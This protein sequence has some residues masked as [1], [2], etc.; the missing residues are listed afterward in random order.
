MRN[1][2][3]E[4]AG[5]S[6]LSSRCAVPRRIRGR[7]FSASDSDRCASGR[8]LHGRGAADPGGSGR[9][10]RRAPPEIIHPRSARDHGR[11]GHGHAVQRLDLQRQIA[12]AGPGGLRRGPRQDHHGEPR[13]H[14]AWAG[15]TCVPNQHD[16]LRSGRAGRIHGPGQDDGYPRR[17]HVP[18]RLGPRHRPA[19]QER[20]VWSDGGLSA[21]PEASCGAGACGGGERHLRRPRPIRADPRHLTGNGRNETIRPS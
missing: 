8:A 3:F 15:F 10:L 12:C 9:H 21:R 4:N 20:A 7:L 14:R 2:T 13:R 1:E 19:H 11:S 5:P 6:P 17:V 16:A 18:L